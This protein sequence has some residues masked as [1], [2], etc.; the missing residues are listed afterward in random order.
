MSGMPGK[1]RLSLSEL[2]PLESLQQNW[3]ALEARAD[4]SFFQSWLWIGVWLESLPSRIAPLLLR[5]ERDGVIIGLSILSSRSILRHG[6]LRSRALF[7]N[8]TGDP[9]FDE[10]TIE[11]NGFLA[12]RGSEGVVTQACVEFLLGEQSGWE[13]VFLDGLRM[14]EA[15]EAIDFGRARLRATSRRACHVVNLEQLRLTGSDYL[16]LLGKNT[17]YTIRRSLR[18]YEKRGAVELVEAVSVQQ[19]RDFLYRLRYLHQQYWQKKGMPGSFANLFFSD[20]H[21]RLVEKGFPGGAIQMLRLTVGGHEIGYLYN[22]IHRGRVY[23]YQSGFDYDLV[24][25]HGRPGLVC[26]ALAIQHNMKEGNLVYDFMAGD[27]EHK[28]NLATASETMVWCVIQRP[29]L[30]FWIEDILRAA[31]RRLWHSTP[32]QTREQSSDSMHSHRERA[33]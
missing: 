21:D 24:G 22:F 8:S 26:H 19:A 5:V 25:T 15:I 2:P 1:L 10:I 12:E 33:S 27:S 11:H 3:R 17:R 13:E 31:K 4:L 32:T 28:K 29:R 20:F 18:A 6:I 9:A 7:L 16:S 14:P 23:N 30:K